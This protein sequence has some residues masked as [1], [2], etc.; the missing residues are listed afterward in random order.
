M[1]C[2]NNK[3]GMLDEEEYIK[4]CKNQGENLTKR[5]NG[6]KFINVDEETMRKTW[7]LNQFENKG[8]ITLNDFHKKQDNDRRLM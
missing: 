8:G 3:N 2:D 7:K 1:A 6:I 4:F 5:M